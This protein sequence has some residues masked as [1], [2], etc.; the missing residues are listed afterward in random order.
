MSDDSDFD[1]SKKLGITDNLYIDTGINLRWL[2]RFNPKN[3]VI[4]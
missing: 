1:F 4:F 2:K 3:H